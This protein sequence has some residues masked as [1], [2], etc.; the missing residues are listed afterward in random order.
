[1]IHLG[2]IT[3]VSRGTCSFTWILQCFLV[4]AKQYKMFCSTNRLQVH[5]HLYAWSRVLGISKAQ[6]CASIFLCFNRF[7]SGSVRSLLSNSRCPLQVDNWSFSIDKK[8]LEPRHLQ[9]VLSW[10]WQTSQRTHYLEALKWCQPA[11]LWCWQLP[12]DA[13]LGGAQMLSTC[14]TLVLTISKGPT[15]GS[16]IM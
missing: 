4:P 6:G 11:N 1:M 16:W 9:K 3:F 13:L 10:C 8:K 15:R 5:I 2:G 7:G 12:K 14:Q